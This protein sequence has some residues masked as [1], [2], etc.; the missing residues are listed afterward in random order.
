MK[1]IENISWTMV[2]AMLAL[3]SCRE[4]LPSVPGGSTKEPVLSAY[5]KRMLSR[6]DVT[7][8]Q[9]APG[10][11]YRIWVTETG[12]SDPHFTD[13]ENGIEG[14]EATREEDQM[15]YINLGSNYNSQLT[16]GLDFYGFTD[17]TTT[18]PREGI[19]EST[20]PIE[21]NEGDYIDYRRG[22]LKYTG[23]E[24]TSGVLRMPF[25]HIM[26]QVKL[27]VM[28][29]E[30]V[31]SDLELVSVEFVGAASSDT[32]TENKGVVTKG[33]YNV[34]DNTFVGTETKVRTVKPENGN[35]EIGTAAKSIR[36]VLV[37]PEEQ[38]NTTTHYLRVTFNDPGKFYKQE[39]D[40][41]VVYIPIYDN[42][43]ISNDSQPKPIPL[44]FEQN[45]SYTLCISFL[46]D[47]ARIVTL[48]PQVYE[49]LDGETDSEDE[50]GN[51]YQEQDLGQPVT[52][53]GVMWSDRN[54]GATSAHPTRSIDDWYK[55]VGYFYQYGRN[56]PYFP[57]SLNEDGTINL[58]TPLKEA[59]VTDGETNGKRPLYPVVNF[60]SW[61][62]GLTAESEKGKIAPTT[63][64]QWVWK[65]GYYDK[66]QSHHWG[67]SYGVGYETKYLYDYDH[68]W[69]NNTNTPCPPGWRLPTTE[70]YMGIIPGSVYSGNITF[71][72]F[73]YEET[74]GSWQANSQDYPNRGQANSEPDFEEVY[75]AGNLVYY[76]GVSGVSQ[77]QQVYQGAFPCLY[78][79]ENNDPIAGATSKYILSM[80]DE[81]GYRDWNRVCETAG[82]LRPE[83]KGKDYTYNW[84]VIYGIKNQGKATAYRVKWEVK[85]LSEDTDPEWEDYTNKYGRK[86]QRWHYDKP[87]R[88]VLV[89]SRYQAS[90]K[91]DFVAENGDYKAAVK[92]YDW[93]HPVEVMYLPVGGFAD[94]WSNGKLGNIG[95]ELWYAISNR[96]DTTDG[97]L[98][99]IM[100]FKFAGTNTASQS[101]IISS[102]SKMN[103]AV[104]IRCVRDL[105]NK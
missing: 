41:A 80:M 22:Q 9:F 101:M 24:A 79:E 58:S 75:R 102:R 84:G 54:L 53:N 4:D 94:N 38:D 18:A 3:L 63:G 33:T 62:Q 19:V 103:A 66:V 29:E 25:E 93:E 65:L 82:E 10:T 37:F 45:T 20:Y 89:I 60:E 97:T 27:E 44:H 50:N 99:H 1:R 76:K 32:Q 11:K 83:G 17:T 95:T 73:T 16:G 28:K 23:S 2:L 100:W 47:Q 36:T 92:K 31:D 55:S 15:R 12:K 40:N 68:G 61:G 7:D 13:T 105:T 5:K 86:R 88:G 30:S 85:L 96:P 46:S 91:D 57:N 59:L 77:G 56:I 64:E 48:V 90:A 35:L 67:Y 70:D 21:L 6:T 81:E 52:F 78:R 8:E 42:R 74:N 98:K 26:A 14:T 51:K 72:W 69:E 104:Q 43:Q 71:R 87:F 34:Y 49:W 39:A